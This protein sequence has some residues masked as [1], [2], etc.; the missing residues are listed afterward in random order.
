MHMSDE[1][2]R[3]AAMF[4]ALAPTYDT[5]GVI[6]FGPIA[7]G[8]I[9]IL[10]P[11]PGQRILDLGCGRGAVLARLA[12]TVD[13]AVGI[14][15]SPEMVARSR[16]AFAPWPNIRVEVGD[17]RDPDPQ[18]GL[19]N[20]VTASLVLFFL[21]DPVAALRRWR[22]RLTTGGRCVISIF[23]APGAAWQAVDEVFLPYLPAQLR[24]ARTAGPLSPSSP[25]STV[26]QLFTAAGYTDVHT[27]ARPLDTR[28]AGIEQWEQFS[29]STGQRAMWLAVPEPERPAVRATVTDIL[30]SSPHPDGGYVLSQTVRYISGVA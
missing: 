10:R 7:D 22:D 9:E 12:P 4:D 1:V 16:A 20:A 25:D 29:W 21:P 30:R 19:F 15:I 3:I 26:E 23:G 27:V 18:L 13:T 17:A 6:F 2:A 5:T 8:L 28:F 14:D 24:D 11:G